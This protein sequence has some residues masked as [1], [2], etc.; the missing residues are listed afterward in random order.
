MAETEKNSQAQGFMSKQYDIGIKVTVDI[1]M[2]ED[3]SL[4][5]EH[6]F[7]TKRFKDIVKLVNEGSKQFNNID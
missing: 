1:L 6:E 5:K 7:P 2:T 3:R 4:E